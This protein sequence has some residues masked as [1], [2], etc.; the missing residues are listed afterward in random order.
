M[1]GCME[2]RDILNQPAVSVEKLV[3]WGQ[4][5]EDEGMVHDALNFY[6]KAGARGALTRLLERAREDGDSFLFSRT[7]RILGIEPDEEEWNAL[8]E[9]ARSLGKLL[10]AEQAYA[11]AG[12]QVDLS[13]AQTE[14]A[15]GG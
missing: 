3:Q 9:R 10:F 6:E 14:P 12:K 15:A 11:K 2:K 7:S 1:L 8:A 13:D 5:Y 4:V